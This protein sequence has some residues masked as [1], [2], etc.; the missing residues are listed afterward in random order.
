L[1][2][3]SGKERVDVTAVDSEKRNVQRATR[4]DIIRAESIYRGDVKLPPVLSD[5]TS[6]YGFPATYF[7]Q[8]PTGDDTSYTARVPPTK[9]T[10]AAFNTPRILD[11]S[12]CGTSDVVPSPTPWRLPVEPVVTDPSSSRLTNERW[13]F[14]GAQTRSGAAPAT[15]VDQLAALL[16]E[17]DPDRLKDSETRRRIMS[18]LAEHELLPS[19]NGGRRP[20]TEPL[21]RVASEPRR[22]T[23]PMTVGRRE[24][25]ASDIDDAAE[26]HSPYYYCSSCGKLSA[27][28]GHCTKCLKSSMI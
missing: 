8:L 15:D 25:V 21:T 5:W 28:G 14:D 23:E 11:T 22:H 18:R 10:N 13:H 26:W 24:R 20:R 4:D 6:S 1:A 12:D 3:T 2:D 7:M 27:T 17:V 19:N 9:Q 16:Q